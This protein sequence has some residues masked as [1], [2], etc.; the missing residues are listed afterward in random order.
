MDS[1]RTPLVS[2]FNTRKVRELLVWGSDEQVSEIKKAFDPLGFVVTKSYTSAQ[3]V[4]GEL[5]F[6][7]A[8]A[9]LGNSPLLQLLIRELSKHEESC[10]QKIIYFPKLKTLSSRELLFASELGAVFTASAPQRDQ[11]LRAFVKRV[12]LESEIL[13]SVYLLQQDVSKYMKQG[14]EEQLRLTDEKLALLDQS[15]EAVLTLRAMVAQYFGRMKV[16]E[17]FLKRILQLNPQNLWAANQLGRFYLR[18]RRVSEGIAVLGKLSAFHDLNSERL[19]V[20]G[21]AYLNCGIAD[22]AEEVLKKGSALS[23]GKDERFDVGLAKAAILANKPESVTAASPKMQ[24]EII[25][26]LNTRAIMAMKAKQIDQG[27]ELYRQALARA[28]GRDTMKAKLHYN[29]GLS[30]TREHKLDEAAHH[31]DLSVKLGGSIFKRASRPLEVLRTIQKTEERKKK[32]LLTKAAGE[33]CDY[34]DFAVYAPIK[35]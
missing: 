13:G 7:L 18:H 32:E 20:L 9:D 35:S 5:Y 10:V 27:L 2:S 3:Q 23:E 29:L 31:L 1:K 8:F 14:S 12:A 15:S 4:V 28:E 25:S 33:E 19:L 11:E 6:F 24:E 21:D 17:G 26:Y 22:K 16:Y 34:E 30:Y